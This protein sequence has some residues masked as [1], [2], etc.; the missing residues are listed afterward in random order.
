MM[1]GNQ[2]QVLRGR[3]TAGMNNGMNPQQPQ[4]Q[5]QGMQQQ[6]NPLAMIAASVGRYATNLNTPNNS[7]ASLYSY[8]PSGTNY[9]ALIGLDGEV[10]D[11]QIKA[12]A[13]TE[14]GMVAYQVVQI[15]MHRRTN[16]FMY[17]QWRNALERFKSPLR[18][19]KHDPVMEA[20]VN[21][22]DSRQALHNFIVGQAGIQL[23]S[24]IAW[25]LMSGNEAIRQPGPIMQDLFYKSCIDI[26][27]LQFLDHLSHHQEQ[28]H[29]LSPLAKSE[30]SKREDPIFQQVLERYVFSGLECP[31]SKGKLSSIVE[32]TTLHNPLLD[33]QSVTDMGM[34]GNMFDINSNAISGNN[35]GMA[36]A[37]AWLAQQVAR[38]KQKALE[39]GYT[40]VQH[41]LI[42]VP[43]YDNFDRPKLNIEDINAGN[44]H[45]YNLNDYASEVPGTGWYILHRYHLNS[46]TKAFNLEDGSTF[47]MRDTNVLGKLAVYRFDWQHGT[48]AY[49]FIDYDGSEV[50]HMQELLSDPSLLLPY[51]Y[52]DNGVQKTTFDP[53]DME[54]SAFVRDG[55]VVPMEEMK[56]L[57]KMP[58]LL[59]GSSPMK[60]NL[61]NE[62]TLNRINAHTAAHDP[63]SQL[64]AF[65]LPMANT[66]QWTLD[67]ATDVDQFYSQFKL[68]VR[69][70]T[71]DKTDTAQ[72]I[73]HLRGVCREHNDEEFTS[74]VQSYLTNLVN[75]WL[76]EVR[77]YAE[78]KD[79]LSAEYLRVRNIFEDLEELVQWM[80]DRDHPTLRAFMNY[81]SNDFIRNG[82]E[83]IVDKEETR[84]EFEELY[85]NEDEVSRAVMMND[86]KRKIIF[87]RDSVFINLIKENGPHA[88]EAVYIKESIDPKLFAIVRKAIEVG[89]RHFKE[90]PQVLVKF[91]K[92]EGNKVWA[93][94][95]SGFDPE[96]VF[97]LRAVSTFEDYVHPVPVCE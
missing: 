32:N 28:F 31:Y 71:Q 85:K 76:V 5:Q 7:M 62:N 40:P 88:L 60:A 25:Q 29:R 72:V 58:D 80:S 87:K 47:H 9:A 89:A 73:R 26:I 94:T 52:E 4:Q 64:D 56:T 84:K 65:V 10:N 36:E 17:Q 57:D 6:Q 33:V 38:N 53:K 96:G 79:D 21:D 82:I 63:K 15:C 13:L 74:F 93:L 27:T 37:N 70:N 48:F 1:N 11:E 46:I 66:R 67:E 77:G 2:A 81:G 90:Y 50:R 3:Q 83:I 45:Q 42:D 35:Q 59:V 95:R 68:M 22:I 61:G 44:R 55:Y 92:D 75:R 91:R 30:L 39:T 86:A 97:V 43:S 18:G 34:A 19:G 24:V 69:G 12:Q 49:R 41:N 8:G 20:F 78:D 54:T 14:G 16:N 23:G 51:M